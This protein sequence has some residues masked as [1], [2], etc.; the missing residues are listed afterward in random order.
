M[1]KENVKKIILFIYIN[2]V[3][4]NIYGLLFSL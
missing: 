2:I 4:I 1:G 3:N